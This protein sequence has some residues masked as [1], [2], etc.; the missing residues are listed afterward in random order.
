MVRMKKESF[1]FVSFLGILSLFAFFST[2]FQHSILSVQHSDRQNP[3]D[4]FRSSIRGHFFTQTKQDRP[5]GRSRAPDKNLHLIFST[6]CDNQQHWESLVFFHHAYRVQQP[7]TVTRI[8]SGCNDAER[9]SLETFHRNYIQELSPNFFLHFTPNF[10]KVAL[11]DGK[12]PYKYMNKPFGVQH[13]F[14]HAFDAQKHPDDIVILMDPDMILLRPITDDFSDVENH[15]FVEDKPLTTVVKRG[16]PMAQQDGYLSSVWMDLD[17]KHVTNL[18][19]PR[20]YPKRSEGAIHWNTGP[21]YLATAH[22]LYEI[23][24]RW[25]E[26]TP[27]TLEEHPGTFSEMF[28]FIHASVQANLPFTMLKSIVVSDT[29]TKTREAWSFIDALPDDQVCRP[30]LDSK[31]P[32]VLHYCKR[33]MLGDDYFFSKYRLK[34][35]IMNCEKPLLLE[36]PSDLATRQFRYGY[37]APRADLKDKDSYW[38]DRL[39]KKKLMSERDAKRHAFMLC[40]LTSK[41]NDSLERMKRSVCGASGGNLNRTYSIFLDPTKT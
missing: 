15:L 27:R 34:K 31:L 37:D 40:S 26:Y 3:S 33:Y 18:T 28:G 39:L 7:G 38:K 4:V 22:D 9:E 20:P 30:A 41:I 36:P 14:Q 29:S 17:L 6:S 35:N 19:N 32:I 12:F 5:N 2:F 11:K 10:A 23:T 25:T 24:R 16:Y 8:V 1:L 13:W 21:P